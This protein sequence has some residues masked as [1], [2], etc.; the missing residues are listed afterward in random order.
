[1]VTGLNLN[2]FELELQVQNSGT[3]LPGQYLIFPLPS[4][5]R[6]NICSQ[7][8]L[9]ASPEPVVTHALC[10]SYSVSTNLSDTVVS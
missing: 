2:C 5:F 3:P 8:L 6:V 9:V 4:L 10:I 7:S 1:M